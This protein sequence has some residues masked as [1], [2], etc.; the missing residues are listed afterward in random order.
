MAAKI[1]CTAETL[2]RWV[3][4]AERDAGKREGLTTRRAG[5][6]QAAPA[7]EQGAQEGQRDSSLGL[8][9]FRAGG[10][11]PPEMMVAF[12]DDHRAGPGSRVDLQELQFAPSTYYKHKSH[13]RLSRDSRSP[14][15][16]ARRDASMRPYVVCGKTTSGSMERARSGASSDGKA[17]PSPRCTVERL[18]REM[19]LRGVVRG[20][21]KR[22]TIP[23]DRDPRPL[24]L[25]QTAVPRRQRQTS[26]GS[27]ISP[28]LRPGRASST[29]PLSSTYSR[30]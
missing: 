12:I 29:S 23:A 5:R 4:Q 8:S 22:T 17:L 13:S 28:T 24:D 20:R 30:G 14:R 27:P 2:R 25:V 7:R 1:G 16:K 19:G 18:M 26:S 10:A 11:R 9:I 15:R 21:T 6:A 3:R